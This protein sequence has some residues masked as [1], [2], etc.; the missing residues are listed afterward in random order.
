MGPNTGAPL[1]GRPR[2]R[3][4]FISYRRK[5]SSYEADVISE[6][7]VRRG[8]DVFIDRKDLA[9]GEFEDKILAEIKSRPHFVVVMK[10]GSLKGIERPGDWMHREIAKALATGR[11]I[12]PVLMDGFTL[13][14]QL[15]PDIEQ[16]QRY[17]SITIP[18]GYSEEALDR[19]A[20]WLRPSRLRSWLIAAIAAVIV[21]A[22]TITLLVAQ[23]RTGSGSDPVA[24]P[25]ASPQQAPPDVVFADDF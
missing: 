15:P 13:P 14:S 24:F 5:V 2:G 20:E 25:T 10:A 19:L 3:G 1:I 9:A 11:N 18:P 4:V 12:V 21:L 22:V 17:N 8:L 16:L 23:I 7:L 6:G